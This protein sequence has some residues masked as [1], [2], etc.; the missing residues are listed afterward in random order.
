MS[1]VKSKFLKSFKNIKWQPRKF[2]LRVR[3]TLLFVLIFGTTTI[4]FNSGIFL[5]MMKTLQQDFDDA[6][7]NYTLEVS[8]TVAIGPK[9]DLKFPNLKLE[10]GKVLPFPLG[11]ALILIR[12]VSGAVLSKKGKFGDFDPPYKKDVKKIQQGDE[13]AYRTISQIDQIPD[14]EAET[15]R[16][17]TF[18][19]DTTTNPQLFLQIAVPMIFLETQIQNRLNI[20]RFGIPLILLI[21][22]LAGLFVSAR[23]LRPVKEIIETAKAIH[24]DEL[25]QRIPIPR[26]EDEIR[27]LVLTLNQMLDRIEKSFA[28]QERFIADASHQL[29]T[30]VSVMKGELEVY[31]RNSKSTED[32]L[33]Q[34]MFHSLLEET[35]KLSRV[36]QD[37]LLLSRVDEGAG[38]L[39]FQQVYLDEIIF[40]VINSVKPLAQT[41]NISLQVNFVGD[42]SLRKAVRGDSGLLKN[43]I[44]NLVENGLKYS[45]PDKILDVK[46]IWQP[47]E[48]IVQIADQGP[49]I[50]QELLGRVFDRF[51]RGKNIEGKIPGFGLGL[52]IAQKIAFLHNASVRVENL[53]QGGSCFSFSISN[54]NKNS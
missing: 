36:V 10:E 51:G 23:A 15:Y 27:E 2:S 28:S 17:I 4:I 47:H 48:Q 54:E 49:G 11:T 22:T 39:Q 6:L 30:P 1:F 9:G 12:H 37:M 24:T 45:P 42:T 50:S 8:G 31:L 14:A 35:E 34:R 44:R 16:L 53:A 41:K 7:F 5:F 33:A 26:S 19:L 3:L 18:P 46:L 29:L 40:D 25:S 52:S 20:F 13:A 21:A 38:S 43:L 32:P